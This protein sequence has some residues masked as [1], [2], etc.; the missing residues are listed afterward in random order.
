M[1]VPQEQWERAP[2]DVQERQFC[3]LRLASLATSRA[4]REE[5]G[6]V[7]GT[8]QNPRSVAKVAA[9]FPSSR[10]F[11]KPPS[12]GVLSRAPWLWG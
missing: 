12:G 6:R 5:P 4:A 10:N 11:L 1:T 7:R 2:G 3:P 9:S 8:V